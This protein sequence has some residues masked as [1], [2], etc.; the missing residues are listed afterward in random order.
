MAAIEVSGFEVKIAGD[1]GAE[2]LAQAKEMHPKAMAMATGISSFLMGHDPVGWTPNS[3]KFEGLFR[4]CQ[5]RR[6]SRRNS[7]VRTHRTG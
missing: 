2:G 3:L 6:T 1:E 4:D 7:I 5:G